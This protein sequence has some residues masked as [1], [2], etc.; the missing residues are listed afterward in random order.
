MNHH[1]LIAITRYIDS[2]A[3]DA[4]KHALNGLT[5]FEL[6][7]IISSNKIKDKQIIFN[8]LPPEMAARAF[9]L[10]PSRIQ[11][12]CIR[13]IPPLQSAQ[14]LKSLH[15]DKRTEFL[16]ELPQ[17]TIDEL[18]KL[19]P[20][21]ERAQT[22]MLL[23]YPDGS[24]GRLM[25]TDYVAVKPNW[26][27]EEALDHLVAYGH[28]SETINLIYVVNDSGQLLD[29][30]PIT[31]L[32]FVPRQSKIETIMDHVFVALSV[33]END[34]NA[35]N[36]FRQYDRIALPVLDKNDHLVGVVTIDDILRLSGKEATEDI[37]KIGGTVALDEPY[38]Q[39][40]FFALIRKR[41]GWLILLF[42]GEMLTATAMGYF[43]DEIAKAVVLALFLPL[44]IS[45]G[46]NAGSQI[47]TL[48]IRALALGEITLRDWWR[49]IRKEIA[50][51]IVL[52]AI[53]GCIG[54]IRVSVWSA[55]S[56]IYGENWLLIAWTIFF[57]LIGV[58]LW[59]TLIGT[60]MPLTLRLCKLDPATSSAPLVATLVDVMGLVIYF[61]IAIFILKGT[62]L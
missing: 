60:F 59:G 7:H 34:E 50:A 20:P 51:G 38:M 61:L 17:E 43:Q 6:A 42:L 15:P 29:D 14:L 45:S 3:L 54:F 33:Y 46:G 55:F 22:L 18:V 11:H 44:I 35:I 1:H 36:I 58:V 24:V 39:T 13:I 41:A 10:L 21:K 2:N 37:Q 26:R 48:I 53:L 56:N 8:A 23:G 5:P 30:I 31:D 27:V 47:S 25:T 32:L 28:K 19:L 12:D 49:I 62:L 9:E 52:G 4:L 16:Q 57:S 40:P